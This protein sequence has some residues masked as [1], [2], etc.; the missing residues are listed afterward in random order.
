[1]EETLATV[2]VEPIVPAIHAATSAIDVTPIL[3]SPIAVDLVLE[4]TLKPSE[5]S[6]FRTDVTDNSENGGGQSAGNSESQG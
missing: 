5:L 4:D 6:I 2:D 1:M 3:E